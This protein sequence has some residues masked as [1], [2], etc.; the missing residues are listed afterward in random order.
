M[1]DSCSLF[2]RSAYLPRNPLTLLFWYINTGCL[3]ERCVGT[4]LYWYILTCGF[5]NIDAVALGNIFTLLNLHCGAGIS[6]LLCA[7]CNREINTNFLWYFVTCGLRYLYTFLSRY[8]L[9][10]LNFYDK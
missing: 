9:T 3:G 6:C 4:V 8:T 10:Y 7:S 5:W 2:Q 1:I